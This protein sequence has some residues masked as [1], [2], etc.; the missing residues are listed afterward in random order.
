MQK[1]KFVLIAI[2]GGTLAAIISLAPSNAQFP[3]EPAQSYSEIGW[4]FL[5]SRELNQGEIRE[6]E[7]LIQE[8][9]P[10]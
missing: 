10:Q 5:G 8:V 6:N 9:S 1:Y 4:E 2:L 7:S 3:N